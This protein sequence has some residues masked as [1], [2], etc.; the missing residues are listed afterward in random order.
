MK[1]SGTQRHMMECKVINEHIKSK[2]IEDD[3]AEYEDIFAESDRQR[4]ETR[5]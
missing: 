3:K 5:I 2:M 1:S 4:K